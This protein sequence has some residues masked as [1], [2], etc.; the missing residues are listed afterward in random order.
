MESDLDETSYHLS[1]DFLTNAATATLLTSFKRCMALDHKLPP[2]VVRM[3]GMSGRKYRYFINNLVGETPK[4]RYMEVGSWAG[5]TACAAMH[6]NKVDVLC[7]DNWSEFGGPKDLFLQNINSNKTEQVNFHLIENDFRQVDYTALGSFNIYLF[8]GPHLELDQYDGVVL[9]QAALD[10]IYTLI[11]DDWNFPTIRL[12]TMNALR[13]TRSKVLCS[14]T[15]RTTQNDL[16]PQLTHPG[17]HMQDSEWHDGYF[18]A[19]CQK[20]AR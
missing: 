5:S 9:P 11:V 15:I 1:G 7:I 3:Q 6:G 10:D 13:D 14:I 18:F 8:D 2:A 12:G 17:K 20:P 19:V 4:A 16:Y